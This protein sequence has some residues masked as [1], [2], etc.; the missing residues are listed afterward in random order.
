MKNK[1]TKLTE[2]RVGTVGKKKKKKNTMYSNDNGNKL[3]SR[4]KD[5]SLQRYSRARDSRED[6]CS[7]VTSHT[8]AHTTHIRVTPERR[9][10]AN[11]FLLLFFFLLLL[12]N[13]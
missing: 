4:L 6:A 2:K 10:G 12:G 7:N 1:R 3:L 8:R 9:D 5:H 13:E 11:E